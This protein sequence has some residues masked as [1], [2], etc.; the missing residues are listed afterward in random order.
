MKNTICNVILSILETKDPKF[1]EHKV[2]A[3][4]TQLKLNEVEQK[5]IK[6]IKSNLSLGNTTSPSFISEKYSYYVNRDDNIV[7]AILDRDAVDS[8][9]IDIRISQLKNTLSKDMLTLG[10][11]ITTMTPEEI[12]ERMSAL[13]NNLLIE[14]KFVI[15]ENNIKKKKDAYKDLIATREGLSLCLDKVEAHAGLAVKGSVV[16]ILAFVGAF[17]ST[18]SLNIAYQNALNGSNI[19]YLALEDTAQKIMDRMVLN[20]ITHTAEHRDQLISSTW[21][22]D[23][24]LTDKQAMLYDMNH[25]DLVEKLDNHFILWDSTDINYQTFTDMSNVLRLADKEFEEKTG[26]GLDAVIVDQLS[27]LKYTKGS[28]RKTSYDGQILND[29]VSFFREQSL[30]FLDDGRQIVTFLVAQTSRDAFSEASKPKNKGRYSASCTSDSHELERTSSTM[31]TLFKDLSQKN[32]LLINV[33]KARNG[34]SPDNPIQVE[35]YGEYYHVGPLK[36]NADSISAEDFES[37]EVDLASLIG[38]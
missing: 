10:S 13:H 11:Q 15:P 6:D 26:K 36:F 38:G 3:L 5:I 1:I 19:L 28:G 4:E 21:V 37:D 7:P 18:Y 30:N 14:D 12:K 9:I 17:K 25:N 31:I 24:S 35:V 16:S 23:G 20:H 2:S 34:Y 29:W 27:L 8:A 33:P 22:R 32:T